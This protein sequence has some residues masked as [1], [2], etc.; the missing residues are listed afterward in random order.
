MLYNM[1]MRKTISLFISLLTAG[2]LILMP[3]VVRAQTE[4]TTETSTE[5]TTKENETAE[6]KTTRT[7]RIEEYKKNLKAKLT[8]ASKALVATRCEKAQGVAKTRNEKDLTNLRGRTTAYSKIVAGLE[9]TSERLSEKSLDVS[10]LDS[11]IAT[12]KTKIENFNTLET[13]SRQALQD[14][15]LLDCKSDPEAFKA[16]LEA[17]RTAR[18]NAQAAA[19]EVRSY[20]K[21]VVKETLKSLK[22]ELE[23]QSTTKEEE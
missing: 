4:T 23:Q 12:L 7:A 8:E 13:T 2:N 21:D 18:Q 10:T 1:L 19:K 9:R 22:A 11:N 14:L 17:A 3:V 5:V 15:T 6:Q 20:L 16:A